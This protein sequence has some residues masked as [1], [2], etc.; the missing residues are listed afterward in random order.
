MTKDNEMESGQISRRGRI[1]EEVEV[2]KYICP[3]CSVTFDTFD[4]LKAHVAAER[5]R[6]PEEILIKL[7][8]NGELYE[9]KEG[10]GIQ[11]WHTLAYTLRET[12]GLS[13][14]KV[15][16]DR[17]E[18]GACTV[19]VNG[20]PVLSCMTLTIECNGKKITTIEGLLDRVTGEVHPIQ[21][22]FM[23]KMG[24]QCGFCTP[25]MIMTTKALLDKNP[26]PAEKEVK[27]ALSGNLCRCTGY[28]KIVESVLAAAEMI[29]GRTK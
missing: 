29:G 3:Y 16:C 17:G 22:A 21:K 8:V 26:N 19:L 2:T 27:E 15:S 10:D 14:T 5:P 25:G 1:T 28:V 24:F 20:K 23:E 6:I 12:L 13:G 7:M 18:C 4:T 11:P 9:L